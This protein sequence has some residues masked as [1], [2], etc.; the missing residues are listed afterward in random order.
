MIKFELSEEDA[1]TLLLVVKRSVCLA[2]D[3]RKNN[4]DKLFTNNSGINLEVWE[5]T[6]QKTIDSLISIAQTI[7]LSLEELKGE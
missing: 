3:N 4:I 1:H 2:V 7:G 6:Y 5:S